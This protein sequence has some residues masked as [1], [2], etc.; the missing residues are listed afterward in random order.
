L[1]KGLNHLNIKSLF[2]R[3]IGK[4]SIYYPYSFYQKRVNQNQD[5]TTRPQRITDISCKIKISK[6]KVQNDKIFSILQQ[7]T[8]D[9]LK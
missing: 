3:N 9:N 2:K 6:F 1:R 5:E 8:L 4:I 7:I